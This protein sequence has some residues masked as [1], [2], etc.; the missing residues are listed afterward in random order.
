VT[1]LFWMFMLQQ[2]I[3]HHTDIWEHF[4]FSMSLPA[5]SGPRP[6]IQFRNHFSQTVGL[7]GRVISPSQ[8]LYLHTGQYQHRIKAY[9]HQTSMSWLGFVPTIAE[10]ERAKTVHITEH[11]GCVNQELTFAC[12]LKGLGVLTR[13]W[14][15]L[16]STS[17]HL[18][19][20]T[21][22]EL[23]VSPRNF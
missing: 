12:G 13:N 19:A 21:R 8:G 5:H 22:R 4:L 14:V 6:F 16:R 23:Y 11:L 3:F 1:S 2:R 20:C 7:L 17:G 10:S 18:I 15:I 9:T